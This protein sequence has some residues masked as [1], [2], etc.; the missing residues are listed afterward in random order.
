MPK[1]LRGTKEQYLHKQKVVIMNGLL[2]NY[3]MGIFPPDVTSGIREKL[4]EYDLPRLNGNKYGTVD[5]GFTIIHDDKEIK[6]NHSWVY[7]KLMLPG[8]MP[9]LPTLTIISW[10]MQSLP[11]A[12]EEYETRTTLYLAAV[13]KILKEGTFTWQNGAYWLK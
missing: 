1:E 13:K 12:S 11:A 7:A 6:L 5:S 8:G 9:S 4:A 3:A 2:F 10:T